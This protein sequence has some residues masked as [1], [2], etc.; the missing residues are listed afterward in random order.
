MNMNIYINGIAALNKN[1]DGHLTLG[2]ECTLKT[3]SISEKTT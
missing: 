2:N 1:Y 3:S